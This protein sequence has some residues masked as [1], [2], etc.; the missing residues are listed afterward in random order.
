LPKDKQNLLLLPGLLCDAVLWHHQRKY[1]DELAEITV[2]DFTNDDSMADM[3]EAALAR[4]PDQFALAGLS[5]GGYVALEIMRRAPERVTRLALLDTSAHGEMETQTKRRRELINMS[6][7]GKFREVTQQ[8]LPFLIHPDRQ[9][10][11]A[12]TEAIRKMAHHVGPD[13][14]LRQQTAIM[15]RA[16]SR[17][18]LG[19]IKC[20]TL[21]LCGRQDL[22]TPVEAHEEMAAGISTARL[23]IIE[24]CG[25]MTTMERP[26][27]VTAFLRDWL[28][29][30]LVA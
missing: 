23:V 21:I 27:A 13:A 30:P 16:D 25:H 26:Q 28:L 2:A 22:L 15:G 3:A 5:M 24:D 9:D 14:F 11:K 20:P 17:D 6:M 10:D 1:L 8:N 19:R 4:A 29:Y 18:Y 7:K 12:L